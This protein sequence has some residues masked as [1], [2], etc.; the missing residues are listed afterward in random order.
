[1]FGCNACLQV[2]ALWKEMQDYLQEM[3]HAHIRAEDTEFYLSPD[4]L[5]VRSRGCLVLIRQQIN[6]PMD[7]HAMSGR[8]FG[9]LDELVALCLL[10]WVK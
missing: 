7:E 8:S 4:A 10:E 3:L 5:Q 2:A 1:M 9:A 6:Q